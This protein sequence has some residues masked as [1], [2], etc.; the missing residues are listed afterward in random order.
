MDHLLVI[1]HT[2]IYI[3]CS[4]YKKSCLLTDMILLWWLNLA[5]CGGLAT[6]GGEGMRGKS[7]AS[8]ECGVLVLG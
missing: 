1:C 6:D 8:N 5:V 7:V 4:V 2:S 3:A